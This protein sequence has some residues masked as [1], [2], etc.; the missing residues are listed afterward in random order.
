MLGGDIMDRAVLS[1]S[2]TIALMALAS[3]LMP[4]VQAKENPSQLLD[5][6]LRLAD[7]QSDPARKSCLPQPEGRWRWLSFDGN[8]VVEAAI[9][10]EIDGFAKTANTSGG[11][12]GPLVIVNDPGDFD[13]SVG[14]KPIPGSLRAVV[15]ARARNGTAAWIVFDLPPNTKITLKRSLG[16]PSNMTIDGTCSGVTIDGPLKV[17]LFYIHNQ[18]NVL[19]YGLSFRKTDYLPNPEA[20]SCIRLNGLVDAVAVLHN[21]LERCGDGVID[22][23]TSYGQP[24]PDSARITVAYNR[25]SDHDKVMLF[26]TFTCSLN[27]G[28][29]CDESDLVRNRKMTPTL[30]L[31]LAGNLFIRTTQR[32]PRVYGPVFAHV[33]NNVVAYIEYGTFVSNGARALIEDNVYLPLRARTPPIAVWTTTS[34][35]AMRMDWDVL[36]FIRVRNNPRIAGEIIDQIEPEM[37][38]QPP[39]DLQIVPIH[40]M[41]TERAIGCIAARAGIHGGAKWNQQLCFSP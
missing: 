32:H 28:S 15:E 14:D 37:V 40:S 22:I 23:T 25:I 18:R 19:I 5:A 34:E 16:I 10:D 41:P 20:D 27:S 33:V 1:A 39:Y 21:N 30:S 2:V 38:P 17:P 9:L 24:L 26:G 35:G 36:G 31:T 6:G 7:Q 12:G 13:Q 11:L 3:A 4:S 8:R 29:K